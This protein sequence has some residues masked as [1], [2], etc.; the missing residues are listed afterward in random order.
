MTMPAKDLKLNEEVLQFVKTQ[1]ISEYELVKFLTN[2]VAHPDDYTDFTSR[3]ITNLSSLNIKLLNELQEKKRFHLVK[4][5]C[6]AVQFAFSSKQWEYMLGREDGAWYWNNHGLFFSSLHGFIP[7]LNELQ[8]H[9]SRLE[10]GF[11]GRII[12]LEGQSERTFLEV[13]HFA[14]RYTH[15]DN[16]Y[17]VYGGKGAHKNLVYFIR[18]K[19]DK[20]VRVDLAY[21]GDSNLNDQLPKLRKQVALTGVFRF[22]RDF[23]SAF[24]SCL[25]AGAVTDY[26]QRYKDKS[27]FCTEDDVAAM[28]RES[29]PFVKLLEGRFGIDV[30]KVALGELL[31]IGLLD[32]GKTDGRVFHGAGPLTGTE[33][34]RFMRWV[35]DWPEDVSPEENETR[36]E[37]VF[38]V[39]EPQQKDG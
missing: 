34:S 13:I 17:F 2:W 14:T 22:Q 15:F 26:L 16:H 5:L 37:I 25:L 39:D 12:C 6:L 20:G 7:L 31:A 23:E 36:P 11:T 29:Q 38:D 30:N 32:M 27:I 10:Q 4:A 8:W 24:P 35:M 33:I 9:I 3:V 1:Q 18:D 19:N 28:L 21:D